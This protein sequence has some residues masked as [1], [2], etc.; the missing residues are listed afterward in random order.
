M[1]ILFAGR[2]LHVA[3]GDPFQEKQRRQLLLLCALS[4]QSTEAFHRVRGG[5]ERGSNGEGLKRQAE[6][7]KIFL[8]GVSLSLLTVENEVFNDP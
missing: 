6:P 7:V 3:A 8:I 1:H 5:R 4:G 2:H